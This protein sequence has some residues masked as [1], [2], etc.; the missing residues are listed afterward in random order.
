[1]C[2]CVY[3][4]GGCV[5]DVGLGLQTVR[6]YPRYHALACCVDDVQCDELTEMMPVC[7]CFLQVLATTSAEVCLVIVDEIPV[8]SAVVRSISV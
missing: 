8:Y 3:D 7:V 5:R 1:M 4:V 6:P 2:V